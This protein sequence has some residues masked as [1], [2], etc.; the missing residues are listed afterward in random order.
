MSSNETFPRRLPIHNPP[1][2][3]GTILDGRLTPPYVLAWVCDPR[4]FYLNVGGGK[5]GKVHRC[6]FAQ[7]VSDKWDPPP[8]ATFDHMPLP[9]P[10]ADGNFYLIAL[11]NT[12]ESKNK[13]DSEVEFVQ[14]AQNATADP[15]IQ[16]ARVAMGVDQDPKLEE[17]LQWFR[18]PLG[19]LHL[20]EHQRWLARERE[21][22]LQDE[23]EPDE[24]SE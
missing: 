10:G 11:W 6:N 9:Y 24:D 2:P 22:E 18:W 7:A 21:L 15:I 4:D 1:P 20:E 19:W 14:R 17:T 12:R 3:R 5:P 8:D 16:A 23:S 13:R